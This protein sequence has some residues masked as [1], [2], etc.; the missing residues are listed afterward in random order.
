MERA[1]RSRTH[2][3]QPSRRNVRP[4]TRAEA[5]RARRR[6]VQQRK[7]RKKRRRIRFI[8]KTIKMAVFLGIAIGCGRYL[9]TLQ[10]PESPMEEKSFV[11]NNVNVGATVAKRDVIIDNDSL[12]ED[13]EV[14]EKLKALALENKN[15]AK[16]YVDRKKYPE[17]LLAGLAN[18]QEMLEFVMGYL[19][20]DGTVTGGFSKQ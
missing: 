11:S 18:N 17:E 16:I 9:W 12:L 6:A 4:R 2:N 5:E 19:T 10:T 8:I 3:T 20:N 1:Q 15:I 13:I 7:L 14:E